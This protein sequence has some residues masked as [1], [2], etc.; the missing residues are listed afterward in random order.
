MFFIKKNLIFFYKILVTYISS[1]NLNL[2]YLMRIGFNILYT[3]FVFITHLKQ[4]VI[5]KVYQANYKI[6]KMGLL[7]I[8]WLLRLN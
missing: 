7:G 6:D 2:I 8:A 5:I 1:Q 4:P 3:H